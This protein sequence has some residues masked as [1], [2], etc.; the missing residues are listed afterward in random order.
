MLKEKYGFRPQFCSSIVSRWKGMSYWLSI[1]V[2]SVSQR[3]LFHVMLLFV[4][5]WLH[6][7]C[8]SKQGP[9]LEEDTF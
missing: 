1:S 6:L 7:V 9:E 4:S 3:I 5:S 8:T 2:L